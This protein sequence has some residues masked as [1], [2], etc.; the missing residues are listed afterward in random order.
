LE[1]YR[2][3]PFR[4]F[5]SSVLGLEPR[6][7]P[8]EGL[9]SAQ[10]GNIYHRI[11][12]HLYREVGAGATLGALLEALPRVAEA[13]LDAAPREERFRATAWWELTRQQIREDVERSLR[14]LESLAGAE[15]GSYRFH[16]AERTFGI[17]GRAGPSLVIKDGAADSFRVRGFIDRVD[18]DDQNHVR[19]IDYKTAGPWDF[20]PAAVRTGKKL[21]L[22]IYALAAQ[23]ALGLGEVTEGFYWHVRHARHSP[24]QLSRFRSEEGAGP[25][26]AMARAATM[27]WE[28][29]RGAR[30]GWF[31]PKPPDGGCPSYCPA[32]A[33]CWHYEAKAW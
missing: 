2:S 26:A 3:C 28:A 17:A 23:D 31:V 5:V 1:T 25:D 33:F 4:F 11:F 8:T 12:E 29:V 20:T 15:P 16:Q 14:V 18:R 22:P 13:V 24:L 27:A 9:D 7:A 10:L 32:V 30:A 21:Q 19:I 6:E